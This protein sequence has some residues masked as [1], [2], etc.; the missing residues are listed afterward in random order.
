MKHSI[1]DDW[2]GTF[3]RF[4]ICWPDSTLWRALLRGLVTEPARGFFWDEETGWVKDVLA[5]FRQTVDHNLD[6]ECVIMTCRDATELIEALNTNFSALT[7]AIQALQLAVTVEPANPTITV[8]PANPTITVNPASPDINLT[9]APDV[10]LVCGGGSFGPG[11]P[12]SP[13]YGPYGQGPIIQPPAN[14]G[15]TTPGSG[16]GGYNPP[17]SWGGQPAEYDEYKCK[18][19]YFLVD[20]YINY[21]D[22]WARNLE[23]ISSLNDVTAYLWAIFQGTPWIALLAADAIP[24][25]GTYLVTLSVG[26]SIEEQFLDEYLDYLRGIR[27]EWA[28]D[29]YNAPTVDAARQAALNYVGGGGV[30]AWP[31]AIRDFHVDVMFKNYVLNVLFEEHSQVLAYTELVDCSSCE[32]ENLCWFFTEGLEGWEYISSYAGWGF[33]G[34]S[35]E[36]FDDGAA[37][38]N[39]V[40][41]PGYSGMV[42]PYFEPYIVQEGDALCLQISDF[43]SSGAHSLYIGLTIDG[44]ETQFDTSFGSLS[45]GAEATSLDSLVGQEISQIVIGWYHAGSFYVHVD[46]VGINCPACG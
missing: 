11:G 12:S 41:N 35:L 10:N 25:I 14:P 37:Q 23:N 19:S 27:D 2:D 20:G 5:D 36:W 9:C 32:E 18:A 33:A 42:S 8:N 28:C 6:L 40:G 3:C 34:G 13:G 38:Q 7:Q 15:Q 39:G 4:A 29:F 16:P 46:S 22:G 44:E 17:A 1:P 26:L 21:V 31:T 30:I 45:Q 43:S 24:L